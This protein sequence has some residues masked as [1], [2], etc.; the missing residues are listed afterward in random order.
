M[1]QTLT[2]DEQRVFLELHALLRDIDPSRW[3]SDF[4][5]AL[6]DRLHRI[7]AGAVQMMA[8]LRSEGKMDA[9]RERVDELSRALR[10][11]SP[12]QSLPSAE[13][14][15]DEWLHF[16]KSVVPYYELCVLSLRR[17]AIQV[18]SLRPTN[19]ARTA[20]HIGCGI[21][22]IVLLE[23][24]L[25]LWALPFAAGGFALW[26]WS[27]EIARRI[28]PWWNTMLFKFPLFKVV[29]H[30]REV[31]HVNSATWFA[32][33]IFVLALM[34]THI[35]PLVA[36]AVVTFGDPAAATIGRKWGKTVLVNG[37]TLEGCLALL[38]VGTSVGLL[39]LRVFH[40]DVLTWPES[41]LVAGLAALFGGVAELVSRRLDDN[42]TVPL[43]AAGG[44]MLARLMIGQGPF[45]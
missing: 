15:R 29:A 39:G 13:A 45:S 34:Q 31:H 32:T 6:R 19:Y 40:A 11:F 3:R 17:Q 33:S 5:A 23:W 22:A 12:R 9:V 26:C 30:P 8:A 16:R 43:C 44:A 4:D 14:I 37:R 27:M 2:I 38:V 1:T 24:L 42:L 21:L 36:A 7:Q 18:P 20:L 41:I 35:V 25:P 10:D 28:W